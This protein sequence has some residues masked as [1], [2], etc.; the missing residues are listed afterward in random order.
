MKK[1]VYLIAGIAFLLCP[2]S[3]AQDEKVVLNPGD[4]VVS[5]WTKPLDEV[6]VLDKNTAEND[7]AT[8]E[9]TPTRFG[10]D[11]VVSYSIQLAVKKE[12]VADDA[13]TY[14]TLA[15]TNTNKYTVKVKD[16]NAVL[17]TAGAIKRRP[18]DI[19]MRVNASISSA[20][21]TLVSDIIGFNATTFST[22]PDLL[23]VVGDYCDFRT[24]RAEVLYSPNWDG[25]Y[26]GYVYLP[27]LA[28]GIKLIEELNPEVEWGAPESFTPKT[29]LNLQAGGA[30]IAPG[31][32]APGLNKEEVLDGPGFYRMVVKL[33][34]TAKT[35]TLYKFYKEF[36]IC[37][38]RN[39]NYPQWANAMASQNPE[40]GTGVTLTYQPADK[41]WVAKHAYV[42]AFQTDGGGITNTS[43]FEFKLRANAVGKTWANA[44]NL[45][46][47]DNKMDKGIQ[48][49]TISGTKNIPVLAPEGYYDFYV[50]LQ[51]YPW[52]YEMRP[53]VE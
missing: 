33:T 7:L 39:M 38:Q 15:I 30:V 22:D 36:F 2:A 27:T 1:I 17:T 24:S 41:V 32:F 48:M 6:I 29:S 21:Q 20:Y 44:A 40:D 53:S 45:G 18:T 11:A 5:S 49:G 13:L 31:S 28:Q 50:Y 42:P 35:I 47:V 26:E 16:L 46:A 10:Y 51:E 9:W 3:C 12:G 14:T 8:L 4:F 25:Q 37:G 23:Y 43:K 19:V 34:E 52:R